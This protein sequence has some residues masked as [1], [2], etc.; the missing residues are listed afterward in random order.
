MIAARLHR[1]PPVHL[2]NAAKLASM[3]PMVAIEVADPNRLTTPRL[4]IRPL[5][6]TDRSE[7]LRVIEISREHLDGRC[8]L[9]KDDETDDQLFDRLRDQAAKGLELGRAWRA[10]YFGRGGRLLGLINLNDIVRGLEG[11]AE[12]NWWTSADAL[13]NGYATEAV[14]AV[15]DHAFADL[16][17][18]L[19]LQRV[20]ALIA[21]D[22][23]A[24]RKV[25]SRA[26]FHRAA[27]KTSAGGRVVT[28]PLV[29]SGRTVSHE[30]FEA[31]APITGSRR[32]ASRRPS[33][34]AGL[35]SILTVESAVCAHVE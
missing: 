14:R 10:A 34:R 7:F 9:H 28:C 1:S 3:R 35:S 31:F 29:L 4:T 17:R 26:G 18:G 23:R 19:G 6:W 15:L 13:G 12:A 8:P 33:L 32:L 21:P 25:A 5:A 2:T 27:Q 11:Q 24:S 30:L 16:P 20:T 22:N